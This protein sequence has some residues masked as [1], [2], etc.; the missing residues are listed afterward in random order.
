MSDTALRIAAANAERN[1]ANV[2]FVKSD[3]FAALQGETFDMIVS[4]PPYISREEMEE[5]F[6]YAP[7]ALDNTLVIADK[8][9]FEFEFGHR[10]LPKFPLP[11]GETDAETFLRKLCDKGL[12]ERYPDAH[13]EHRERLE[14]EIGVI[15]SMGFLDYFLIVSDFIHYA[16]QRGI[17]V[18]PGRGSAAGSMVAYCLGITEIDPIRYSLYFERFL[19]PERVSMPDIDVDF[20][21]VRRQEVIDYV[22]KKYG[23]ENVCQIITFGTMAARAAVRDVGRALNMPYAEVD[24]VAKRVPQ[25]LKMTLDKALEVSPELKKL[26]T[27]DPR[28]KK[29]I[30]TA[31]QLEGMPR[32]ASTHAAGVI[33]ASAPVWQFVPMAKTDQGI[34]TQFGMITLEE[35]GLLKMDFLGLRNL[36][37]L[38]DAV[39]MVRRRG[40]DLDMDELDYNDPGVYEMLGKGHTDGVFQLESAGMTSVVVGMHPGS[41]EDITAIVALYRPGPMASIGTYIE[42]KTDPRTIRYK[43]PLLEPILSV[44]YGCV[45]YQEQVMEI[46]RVLAGYSLG[47]ADMVRRAMSK[48]KMDALMKERENFLHGNPAEGIVGC[49]ANGVPEKVANEIFDE[50]LDFANYAFNKAHAVCYAVLAYQTAYMKYHYPKE[51]MAALL[52]SVQGLSSKVSE[53]IASARDLGIT[54]LPPDV[55]ESMADFSVT[56]SG[57]R[58][59]MAAIKN[60]G[61]G[62]IE[63]MTQEREMNGRFLNFS[64]FCER[65]AS[66]ADLNKRA[67]ENMI[68]AGAFDSMGYKRSQLIQVHVR[69][70]D[71]AAGAAKKNLVG[72]MDLFSG[73]SDADSNDLELP[74]IE[75]YTARELLSME[76]ETTGLY[77]SGH[78]M[79][80]LQPLADKVRAVPIGRLLESASSEE[81]DPELQDN[82]YIT[83]AGVITAT[84]TKTTKNNTTMA[85]ATLEDRTGSLELLVFASAIDQGGGYLTEDSA[86]IIH[87]RISSR[88]D[89]EPKVVVSDI[90]PLTQEYVDQYAEI[91]R[92]SRGDRRE[93]NGRYE[94]RDIPAPTAEEL[95]GTPPQDEVPVAQAV[96]EG[97]LYLRLDSEMEEYWD[98]LKCILRNYPGNY[99][100]KV[101]FSARKQTMAANNLWVRPDSDLQEQLCN[102]LGEENVVWKRKN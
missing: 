56:D 45:V 21:Y 33:I 90:Y 62:F 99:N 69:V 12:K 31:R 94:R 60:V 17:P 7:E 100:I 9:N 49:V 22:V 54:V 87:G 57:I 80:G 19:N 14:Y 20:C 1:G 39:K 10:R 73:L 30:D 95:Y 92:K 16:K 4:N 34:V 43:H 101:H 26:Y 15:K 88:E 63:H 23:S 66:A 6:P 58:F 44:T 37:I 24:V 64:D 81:P 53:Y 79:D 89:E 52:T 3:C 11:A 28:V 67:L 41:V 76:K 47:K 50:L 96:T 2:R 29:L 18:G 32:N 42:R 75:E 97:T 74:D 102:L 38:D 78:P 72:Q 83:V 48:K 65:M 98:Q 71:S 77:L 86:V 8:C 84:K 82:R 61:R 55:N 93:R 59:G 27:D 13:Q 70:L 5:L 68:R 91:R 35:L 25:E 85:Y 40:I 46:F 51:Y 36:T